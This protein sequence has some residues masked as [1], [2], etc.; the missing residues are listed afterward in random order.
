MK[1][2]LLFILAAFM[3]SWS[4]SAQM[5]L[6]FNTTLS[7]GK[8]ITLPL[9]GTV[10]VSVNWGDGK[11]DTYTTAGNHEHPYTAEGIYTVSISGSL[12]HFGKYEYPNADKLVKVTSF[13]DIGLTS[14]EYAFYGAK[15]IE[16]LPSQLPST[17]QN[18]RG[19][20]GV[21][22][23]FNGNISG[24]DVSKVTNMS[25]MFYYASAFNQD[26]SGWNVSKVT[27]MSGML[28]STYQFNQDIS[29][30][31]VSNVTDMELMFYQALV[32]NQNIGGWDVSKVT[33]MNAMFKSARAFNQDISSWDVSKVTWMAYMFADASSF[34][35]DI[36]SWDV[37]K[38]TF[39]GSMFAGASKF[40]QNIGNWDVR[41]VSD[42]KWMFSRATAFDQD[43]GA[44]DVRTVTDMT[45]MFKE[46]TL[47]TYNYNN[48]LI[49]WAKQTVK[50]GVVFSG[51][52]SN[53][54]PGETAD[55][56][57]VLTGTYNWTITDG[58][59]S[60]VLT[61]STYPPK[62]TTRAIVLSGG[63]IFTD[64]GSAVTARGVVWNTSENPTIAKNK[65]KTTD[66]TGVGSFISNITGLTKNTTYYVRAYATNA[67]GTEYG[68]N[69]KF[70][71]EESSSGVSSTVA[72]NIDVY[73]NPFRNE[74]RLSNASDA[75]RIV[76][77]TVTG[78]VVLNQRAKQV[79]ETYL[80]SG[81]YLVTIKANDGSKVV[82]KMIRE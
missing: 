80:P 42:M 75:S 59:E 63:K 33:N 48:L 3:L 66:G 7:A 4:V 73:P 18:L 71:A 40:N 57:A 25:L 67:N 78:V 24:W 41:K 13:G 81:I 31:N 45:D 12:E 62:K 5:V 21:A 55:A 29:S 10:N 6:E 72:D 69:M 46:V 74:I 1:K 47:S 20:L 50:N 43:L 15:N 82:R 22:S 64:G 54:S 17:I 11:T 30:W 27:N 77:T 32:F 56:K 51:G 19:M 76:I 49:N 70:V 34:N 52:N 37:S 23:K 26:I 53:F 58:G 9:Y 14:L 38:V 79:V 39:M 44:W 35:Q 16:K 8:T 36:S 60:N 2:Q 68:A 61:V 28:N 65:G